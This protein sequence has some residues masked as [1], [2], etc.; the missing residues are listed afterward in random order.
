MGFELLIH[1][2]LRLRAESY[3]LS[4][5]ACEVRRAAVQGILRGKSSRREIV[6]AG[7]VFHVEPYEKRKSLILRRLSISEGCGNTRF[8]GL[9]IRNVYTFFSRGWNRMNQ[10]DSPMS[11]AG[12]ILL[13]VNQV[14]NCCV[15]ARSG[16]NVSLRHDGNR[17]AMEG[18]ECNDGLSPTKGSHFWP[19]S[20][21]PTTP[22]LTAYS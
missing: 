21:L 12:R 3:Q 10:N 17:V 14:F 2:S 19:T 20:G 15:L 1:S 13:L 9:Y 4:M 7:A 16:A 22:E 5:R 8:P 11:H 18:C 6:A